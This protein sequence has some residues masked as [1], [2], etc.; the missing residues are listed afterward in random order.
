MN[1]EVHESV[2]GQETAAKDVDLSAVVKAM[3]TDKMFQAESL[4]E[5]KSIIAEFLSCPGPSF[6]EIKICPGSRDDLGRPTIKPVDNKE[7]FMKF[8]EI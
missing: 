2:G 4:S 1:N 6:L 7:N 5:I 8:L 3:G